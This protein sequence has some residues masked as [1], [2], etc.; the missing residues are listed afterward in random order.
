MK[1]DFVRNL[2]RKPGHFWAEKVSKTGLMTSKQ[3]FFNNCIVIFWK[4]SG[5]FV[6]HQENAWRLPVIIEEIFLTA[7]PKVSTNIDVTNH[8]S[9]WTL[10]II[11]IVDILAA[12]RCYT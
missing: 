9:R 3:G 1:S 8:S 10:A 4:R 12:T 7:W 6:Q 2:G 11:T 5:D